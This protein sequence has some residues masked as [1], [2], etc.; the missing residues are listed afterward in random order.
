[1]PWHV[2]VGAGDSLLGVTGLEEA[3]YQLFRRRPADSS[4]S[5]MSTEPQTSALPQGWRD[6]LV[7]VQNANAAA[8]SGDGHAPVR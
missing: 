7:K 1:M 2:A 5:G 4:R 6:R 8:A 3:R